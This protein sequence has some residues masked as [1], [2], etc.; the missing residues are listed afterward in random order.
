TYHAMQTSL[1]VE[2]EGD[3]LPFFDRHR[4]ALDFNQQGGN[5][6]VFRL[7]DRTTNEERW[8]QQNLPTA[9]YIAH[10]AGQPRHYAYAQGHTLI[11]HLNQLVF[12]YDLAAKKELWRYNLF[13]KNAML[14]GANTTQAVTPDEDGRLML[15]FNDGR[16]ERLGAVGVV[17]SSYVALLFKSLLQA[18]HSD[19]L[20]DVALVSD[21]E[22]IYLALNRTPEPGLNWSPNAMSGLRTLKING[23]L[24]ALNRR[25]GKL[26]WVCDF[27]PH[28]ALM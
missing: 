26:E 28:Q 6:T 9:F 5:A 25:S 24:Y 4:L 20:Q 22:H 11:L 3:L 19:R 17:E 27:L 16:K 1:T 2:P 21:R 8:K 23:P 7:L 10:S 15:T 12:A 18:E 13:G 14:Y